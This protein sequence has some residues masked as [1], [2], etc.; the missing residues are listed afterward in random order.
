LSEAGFSVSACRPKGH[1]LELVD[2]LTTNRV[3]GKLRPLRSIIAA[4]RSANPDLVICDDERALALLRR[5]HERVRMAN[6]DMAALL[7]RSLGNVEDWPST[8]SRTGLASEARALNLATP[9]TAVIGSMDALDRWVTEHGVPLA[10]KT[11]G[12]WG[13]RGSHR[14]RFRGRMSENWERMT[15]EDREKFRQGMR[16]RCG[17]FGATTSESKEPA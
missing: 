9:E 3:L 14:S 13:G 4:I 7:A 2:A 10:L 8:T 11:D 12:S 1:P 17:G 15:P 6:P 5:L 16:S